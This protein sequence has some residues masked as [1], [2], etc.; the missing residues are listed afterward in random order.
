MVIIMLTS[1]LVLLTVF[2]VIEWRCVKLPILPGKN[3]D[4][5]VSHNTN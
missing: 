1:G 5:L 3:I 4:L 2:L